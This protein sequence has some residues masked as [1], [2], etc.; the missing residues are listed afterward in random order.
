M[1]GETK[2]AEEL[3][4]LADQVCHLT[5]DRRDPEAFHER[6]SEI[7]AAL[8]RLARAAARERIQ[9]EHRAKQ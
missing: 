9:Q 8:R 5:P 6:K 1:Q 7:A 4:S 3:E 2:V